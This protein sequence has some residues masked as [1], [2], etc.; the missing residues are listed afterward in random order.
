MPLARLVLAVGG[1][2]LV[3]LAFPG[4][5][6]WWAAPL[7]VAL[8]G[9][10][11]WR[12]RPANGLVAGLGAGLAYFA[13]VL[14]WAGTYVG[15]LPWLAL[16]TVESLYVAVMVWL[17]VLIQRPLIAAGR[18]GLAW[19]VVPLGWVVEELARSTTPYGGFP[20]AR[21]AF[22]QADSPLARVAA[23][24][25]A[26]GVTFAVALVGTLLAGAVVA[27]A[28]RRPTGAIPLVAAVAVVVLA[29]LIWLPTGGRP[30][31]VALVQGNVPQAGL[32]FNAQRRAVLDDH[33]RETL[34]LAAHRPADLALV[35]WPEN[36]SD[37]DPIAN[38][39]AAAEI[40]KVV[41]AIKV[42]LLLGAVID[43]PGRYLSNTSLLYRTPTSTP[44]RYV[45]QHP[46]PFAEYIPDRS[47]FRRFSDKVDL[48]RRDFI[49]GGSRGEFHL[50]GP[51]GPFTVVPTICFEIAYDGLVRDEVTHAGP[52]PSLLVVQTNNA[53][54]GRTD[55]AAQQFA[56]SRIRAIEH[57][58][59]VAEV[60]TVGITGFV[61]PD[62][63]ASGRTRLFT[64]AQVVGRPVLRTGITLADRLGGIPD[65]VA[66]GVLAFLAI[67]AAIARRRPGPR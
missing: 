60:S 63:T 2:Y 54:F 23:Y 53:T 19:A 33:V 52:D 29:G 67:G 6:L 8:L 43:G 50:T 45:K 17:T 57:G 3:G 28:G 9:L 41:T 10:A 48:V 26:P 24:A 36:A 66:V 59:S 5:N 22:S 37:I 20:W 47:F 12:A 4:A 64:A 31:T 32:A 35:V 18:N 56:I 38:A 58:R 16:A 27:L 25:G 1:G 46:V 15:D 11:G 30:V 7:G 14:S 55:E 44:E 34:A 13:P 21:L 42:P 61:A 62:G 49:A 65:A 51:A 40:R 39:D